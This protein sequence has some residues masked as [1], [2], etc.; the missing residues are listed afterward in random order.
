MSIKD[1]AYKFCKKVWDSPHRAE[2]W[3][4]VAK[5]KSSTRGF[6]NKVYPSPILGLLLYNQQAIKDYNGKAPYEEL[7]DWSER[8]RKILFGAHKQMLQL[9]HRCLAPLAAELPECLTAVNPYKEYPDAESSDGFE[10]LIFKPDDAEDIIQSFH[11]HP[12]FGVAL[13]NLQMVKENPLDYERLI[14]S[15]TSALTEAEPGGEVRWVNDLKQMK[16]ANRPEGFKLGHIAALICLHD[17]L[18]NLDQLIHQ[19][20]YQET[21]MRIDRSSVI[22][23][24]WAPR[25]TGVGVWIMHIP[26]GYMYI[27]EVTDLI[28]VNTDKP[29]QKSLGDSLCR[30]EIQL[31]SSDMKPSVF[32]M[33]MVDENLNAYDDLIR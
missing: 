19:A 10:E 21:L 1:Q 32:K 2:V 23:Y 27:I 22:D 30:V 33:R 5:L 20:L 9:N 16:K 25:D 24:V 7:V 18:S 26:I 14:L 6:G 3:G 29:S 31:L 11:S 12:A 28:I 17:S 8:E 15:L 4:V 13:S